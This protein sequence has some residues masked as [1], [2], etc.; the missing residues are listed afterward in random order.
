MK[1][2]R[3]SNTI[4]LIF[5]SLNLIPAVVMYQMGYQENLYGIY[6]TAPYRTATGL[7]TVATMTFLSVVFV[8]S[9]LFRRSVDRRKVPTS[10]FAVTEGKAKPMGMLGVWVTILYFVL[11]GYRKLTLIGSSVDAWTFRTIGYND[12][13]RILT[14]G[15][16][17]S[18]RILLPFA[19]ALLL[20]KPKATRTSEEKKLIWLF[21]GAQLLGSLMT[22]DRFP[23]MLLLF[24][25]FYFGLV[26][27]K[28][29][30]AA[31]RRIVSRAAALLAIAGLTTFVQYNLTTFG[32]S[33]VLNT[34]WRFFVHRLVT[35]PSTAAIELSFMVFPKGSDPLF[36]SYSRL[37]ALIGRRYIGIQ[38]DSSLFVTPCGAVGDIWRNFGPTGLIIFGMLFGYLASWLDDVFDASERDAQLLI[39]FC[40]VSL[41]FYLIF[42]LMFSQGVLAQ[43]IFTVVALRATCSK[44]NITAKIG[45]PQSRK[46]V[47]G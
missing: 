13:N 25:F 6:E 41:C 24:T 33:D 40:S 1:P 3:P 28:S 37:G 29:A 16:E 2:A 22:L 31:F 14:A 46:T 35:V 19:L 15:L 39:V 38:Q 17:V 5:L 9:K 27:A 12:T 34:G 21:A 4:V 43:T 8:T 44:V 42:G 7:Y 11:G 47:E 32:L 36:L 20:S 18:R 23:I 30:A 10:G 26:E 45:Y